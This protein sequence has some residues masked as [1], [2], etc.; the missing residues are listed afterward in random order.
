MDWIPIHTKRLEPPK[1]DLYAVLDESLT[2]VQEGDIVLVTS[3]VL[4]IHQGRCVPV[5]DVKDKYELI[6]AEAE[7][8]IERQDASAPVMLTLKHHTLIANAGVDESNG[9]GY[10]ILWPEDI[11][12][13]TREIWEYLRQKHNIKNLGVILTDSVCIP[14]RSGVVGISIAHAG[15]V[16]LVDL[17]GN[18]DLFGRELQMTK[19][20][21]P[22]ALA[23]FGVH[24]MGESNEST[25]LL[26]VRG[27]P[28]TFT[29]E[30]T[31]KLLRVDPKQDIF[32]PLLDMFDK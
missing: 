10:Y 14:L 12:E 17:R 2:D 8:Y 3:K 22:D 23:A 24:L 31:N 4:A 25:P 20:N 9:N 7:K 32:K 5:S 29:K 18:K 15:F 21:V 1:D 16:P 13:A 19:Q 30:D 27:F 26:L 28:A 11:D 6:R